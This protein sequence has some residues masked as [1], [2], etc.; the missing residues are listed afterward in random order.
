MDINPYAAPPVLNDRLVDTLIYIDGDCLVASSPIVLPAR[1]I[2]TNVAADQC[3]QKQTPLQWAPFFKL[4]LVRRRCSVTYWQKGRVS[5]ICIAIFVLGAI[6]VCVMLVLGPALIC[7]L[8]LLM[9]LFRSLFDLFNRRRRL[10]IKKYQDGRFWLAG[11]CPQYI[12]ACREIDGFTDLLSSYGF[13]SLANAQA[14]ASNS[15]RP[16]RSAHFSR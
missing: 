4:M 9:L 6:A 5:W 13:D 14:F 3:R 10:R 16:S 7:S 8:I 15:V 12:Q 11:F 1:C 2:Y